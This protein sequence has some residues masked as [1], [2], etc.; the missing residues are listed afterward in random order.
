MPV[1]FL[2]CFL[3]GPHEHRGGGQEG[4]I[5]DVDFF[6][7]RG[8]PAL[9]VR[10]GGID[11]IERESQGV[12]AQRCVEQ[13]VD[14]FHHL[15]RTSHGAGARR[16]ARP[17]LGAVTLQKQTRQGELL[18]RIIG[19]RGGGTRLGNGAVD[20]SLTQFARGAQFA[21]FLGF[22]RFLQRVD[23]LGKLLLV[24]ETCGDFGPRLEI[25]GV[26][27]RFLRK[28]LVVI[29]RGRA[30][31]RAFDLTEDAQHIGFFRTQLLGRID[32]QPGHAVV[33]FFEIVL[34]LGREIARPP[35]GEKVVTDRAQRTEDD[36]GNSED[37]Q[38]PQEKLAA[39]AFFG[40]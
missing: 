21:G 16:H 17:E 4:G 1:D 31:H 20:V 38:K 18:S 35:T 13:A 32:L 6:H 29:Q 39:A 37:G 8:S 24:A 30:P 5:V 11:L 40:T 9:A 2:R 7:R 23:P 36:Q 19:D 3:S 27:F 14:N 25:V 22:A 33:G 26:E 34:R 15:G 10:R 28:F 12:L